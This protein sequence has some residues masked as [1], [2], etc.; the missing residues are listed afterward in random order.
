[1]HTAE[2]LAIKGLTE[3]NVPERLPKLT[4]N[5]ELDVKPDLNKTTEIDFLL[6]EPSTAL[7]PEV[8]KIQTTSTT[9]TL[10]NSNSPKLTTTI[11]TKREI[12]EDISPPIKTQS[13]PKRRKQHFR[14]STETTQAILTIGG[15]T[16][17]DENSQ[18]SIDDEEDDEEGMN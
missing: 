16:R 3:G 15:Y 14:T 11:S 12:S 18:T 5:N 2:L 10:R 6:A 7:E 9:D 4:D 1:M 8:V 13:K 17:Q